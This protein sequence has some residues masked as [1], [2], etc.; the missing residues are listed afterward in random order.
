M[1]PKK[2]IFI[3]LGILVALVITFLVITN[4]ITKYTGYSTSDNPNSL[5]CLGQQNMELYINSTDSDNALKNI[6]LTDYLQYF[7]IH[8]CFTNNHPCVDNGI[9]D[10]PTWIINGEKYV[11]DISVSDLGNYTGCKAQ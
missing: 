2:R 4:E 1:E 7:K 11:G 6:V 9:T 8:N 10:F 3:S 5:S